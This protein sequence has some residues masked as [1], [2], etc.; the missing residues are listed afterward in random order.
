LRTDTLNGAL[1]T[2]NALAVTAGS[3]QFRIE[4]VDITVA[5]VVQAITEG[6]DLLIGVWCIGT[7]PA[8]A[9]TPRLHAAADSRSLAL[10]LGRSNQALRVVSHA[11]TVVVEAI[12]NF[13][14]R[15]GELA[16]TPVLRTAV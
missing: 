8:G 2:A 12:T 13:D 4:F 14:A 10:L 5:V 15:V 16:L 11:I 9:V 7:N 1:F 3:T 6:L